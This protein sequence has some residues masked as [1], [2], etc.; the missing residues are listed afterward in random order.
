MALFSLF[1][2]IEDCLE[3]TFLLEPEIEHNLIHI[4]LVYIGI[5]LISTLTGLHAILQISLVRLR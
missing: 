3:E 1:V 4:Y 2:N 5:M